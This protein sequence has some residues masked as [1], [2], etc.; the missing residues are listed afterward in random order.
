MWFRFYIEDK[1]GLSVIDSI[2]HF[3]TENTFTWGK[4]KNCGFVLYRG[5]N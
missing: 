5:Q 1:V 4:T 2:P 3:H